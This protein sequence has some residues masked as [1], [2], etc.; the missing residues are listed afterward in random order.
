MSDLQFLFV[1]RFAYP[2]LGMFQI[3]HRTVEER[4]AHLWTPER[5]DSRFRTLEHICLR[6]LRQQTD[7]RF[8]T[9][10]L[11]G[12]ALPRPYRTRLQDLAAA[13]PGADIAFHP[14]RQQKEA[15]AEVIR[16]MVDRDG[17][18]V[19]YVRQDDDDGV[20]RKFVARC[21]HVFSD[22]RPLFERHGRIALDFNRGYR[23]QLTPEGPRVQDLFETHIGVAQ[24]I[25]LK[26]SNP[27]TGMHFPHHRLGQIMPSVS[28]P[29]ALMWL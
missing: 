27:R 29:D 9:L 21:R 14:P 22:V 7:D 2:G 8:R 24:A 18:P 28:I 12:D 15:L 19:V 3:E 13:L 23:I 10:I 6:T 20:G 25:V 17:G 11:T 26:A 4:Q 16:P 5:M 1:V